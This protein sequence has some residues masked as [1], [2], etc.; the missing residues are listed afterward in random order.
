MGGGAALNEEGDGIRME[1]G[2]KI[3][4][5]KI[6]ISPGG[7]GGVEGTRDGQKAGLCTFFLPQCLHVPQ[8]KCPQWS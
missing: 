6:N 8:A 3:E 5:N 2:V 7:T 4:T 1:I